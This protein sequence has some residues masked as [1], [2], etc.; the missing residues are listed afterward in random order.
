VNTERVTTDATEARDIE[1]Q[2]VTAPLTAA[3]IFLVLV[4][5][6]GGDNA[7][8][9]RRL[10]GDL[11]GLT[12]AVGFRDPRA[13]LTCIVGVGAR[14]WD[15]LA[16]APRPA[17]LHEFREIR[18]GPRHAV[19]TP[20]DLLF[21][22]RADR[23]DLCYE[24]ATQ[25]TLRLGDAVRAV[26]EVH[27]FRYFDDRDVIGFVDGTENPVGD[28]AYEATVIGEED[29]R[30]AGGSYVIVQKYLHDLERWNAIPT[31]E[32]ERIVGRTKLSDIELDD[33]VKPSCAHNAL[34]KIV[35]DGREVK[36]IRDNMPFA[37]VGTDEHGTYFIGYARSPDPIEQMLHNMFEGR[38]EGNYDHLLDVSRAVTGT[39][40]F[41]P[42]A[43]LLED[44][45]DDEAAETAT[46]QAPDTLSPPP[47][48]SP[49]T[50]AEDEAP[51]PR[52]AAHHGS[53]NIGSLRG[54][55]HDG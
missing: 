42:S 17:G 39:L 8:A 1:P 6:P 55:P 19:A 36:I 48:D 18:A 34:T 12:R 3:V 33:E 40:F 30:F 32:Q 31:E 9:V 2:A 29:E 27:G 10:L 35:Q 26:D 11:S 21:H 13:Q 38:P 25:V 45:A 53:L 14:V 16:G 20:G 47:V 43:P 52:P 44:L 41:V 24:L 7:D 46:Q 37:T 22:I 15:R 4:V 49:G 23:M 5:R 50:C 51:A 54:A 28:E